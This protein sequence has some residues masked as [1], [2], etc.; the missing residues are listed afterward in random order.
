MTFVR[1]PTLPQR[2]RP[3]HW[4]FLLQ[5]PLDARRPHSG[6]V[7]QLRGASGRFYYSGDESAFVLKSLAQAVNKIEVG[8]VEAAQLVRVAE[9]LNRVPIVNERG[10]SWDCQDWTAKGLEMLRFLDVVK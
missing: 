6:I 3:Y 9:V 8:V 5:S 7:H 2:A 4:V 10:A 1:G